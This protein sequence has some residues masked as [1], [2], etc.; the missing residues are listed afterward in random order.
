MKSREIGAFSFVNVNRISVFANKIPDFL[1]FSP[2]YCP[3]IYTRNSKAFL[4]C[5][6]QPV[7]SITFYSSPSWPVGPWPTVKTC[8]PPLSYLKSS[9]SFCSGTCLAR[10]GADFLSL[11]L[12]VEVGG[13]SGAATVGAAAAADFLPLLFGTGGGEGLGA[14]GGVAFA[15]SFHHWLFND[16]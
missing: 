5:R 6:A 15:G 12:V 16:I 8:P 9:F 14:G 3:R 10:V 2:P 1:F 13:C 11:A 7:F 4:S